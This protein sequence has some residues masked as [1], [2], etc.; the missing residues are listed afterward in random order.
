ML[1]R[2]RSGSAGSQANIAGTDRIT[3]GDD[4][5]ALDGSCAGGES[6]SAGMMM[7]VVQAVMAA[8]QLVV[9][10]VMAAVQ[11]A[12]VAEVAAVEPVVAAAPLA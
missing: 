4:R 9:Q 7:V 3:G 12:N 1:Y 2:T 8:V 6:G 10:V 5:L 11:A